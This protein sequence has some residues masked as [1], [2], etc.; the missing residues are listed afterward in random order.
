MSGIVAVSQHVEKIRL[1]LSMLALLHIEADEVGIVSLVFLRTSCQIFRILNES[2]LQ[3]PHHLL[4]YSP[5]HGQ[6]SLNV[7]HVVLCQCFA[8]VNVLPRLS[9]LGTFLSLFSLLAPPATFTIN[10]LLGI[11]NI[12]ILLTGADRDGA[13]CL[14]F[15]KYSQTRLYLVF[16]HI[17]LVKP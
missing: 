5:L 9:L 13:V 2:L 15:L 3:V 4:S 17:Y 7:L 16:V 1:R 10:I 6:M 14:R 8:V 12:F 11:F